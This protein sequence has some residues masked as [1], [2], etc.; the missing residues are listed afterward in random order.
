MYLAVMLGLVPV[1]Q[2]ILSSSAKFFGAEL[3]VRGCSII[4]MVLMVLFAYLSSEKQWRRRRG[5]SKKEHQIKADM[6]WRLLLP[7]EF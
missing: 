1:G 4:A 7:E 5:L 2:L 6:E 3:A